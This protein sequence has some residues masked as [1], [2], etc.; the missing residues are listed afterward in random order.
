LFK[1]KGDADNVRVAKILRKYLIQNREDIQSY[2]KIRGLITSLTS[3][4]QTLPAEDDF[5]ISCTSQLLDKLASI[6][7]IHSTK[8]LQKAEECTVS[9]FCRRRL[10]VIMVRHKMS[11]T[12]KE[13]ITFIEQGHIRVGPNVITDPAFVVSKTMEDFI[14]WVDDSKIKRSVMKYNDKLDD[15]DLL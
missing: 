3:K 15:F 12:M 7:L 8:S 2:D 5:R 10:P 9:S 13:A 1:W 11:E 6:G 14:Q 4:L